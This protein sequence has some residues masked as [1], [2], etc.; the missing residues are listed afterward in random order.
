LT[1][2]F[3]LL[4]GLILVYGRMAVVLSCYDTVRS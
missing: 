3:W 4:F 1:G 2:V